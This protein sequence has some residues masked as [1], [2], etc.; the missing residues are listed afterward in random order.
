MANLRKQDF[1]LLLSSI[2]FMRSLKRPLSEED[3]RELEA[4]CAEVRRRLY[5]PDT[6]IAGQEE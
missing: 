4:A 1:L 3:K 5:H 6:V 2:E